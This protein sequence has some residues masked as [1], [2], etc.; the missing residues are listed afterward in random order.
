MIVYETATKATT[1]LPI[2][3]KE[4]RLYLQGEYSLDKE[5]QALI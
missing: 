3:I 4:K 5:T 2:M 1:S